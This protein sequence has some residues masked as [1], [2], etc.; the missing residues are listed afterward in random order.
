MK[1]IQT[2]YS[3]DQERD[4][5]GVGLLAN[6][7]GVPSRDIVTRSTEML[8][9]MAHRGGCGCEKNTGDGA[10]ILLGM[11]DAFLRKQYNAEHHAVE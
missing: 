6:M 8:S 4:S 5:C 9:R 10:G 3:L 7:K 2:M 11:P 1:K